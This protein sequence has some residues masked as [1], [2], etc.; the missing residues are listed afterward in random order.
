MSRFL[1]DR[2]VI[3]A[4]KPRVPVPPYLE[5]ALLC[6]SDVRLFRLPGRLSLWIAGLA[7]AAGCSTVPPP[8]T[9]PLSRTYGEAVTWSVDWGFATARLQRPDGTTEV[10]TGNG[11]S[12]WGNGDAAA[13]EL[14]FF[15]PAL[16]SLHQVSGDWDTGEYL[17]WRRVGLTARRRLATT[18]GGA[19]T[20]IASAANVHWS[21]RGVDGSIALEQTIPLGGYLTA[22]FRA[23]AS[24]GLRDYDIGVPEDLDQSAGHDNTIGGAH[25]DILR[26]DAR[27]EP[28]IGLILGQGSCILSFQPY[29]V[30]ARGAITSARCT[31]CVSGVQLLDFTQ[32]LGIAFALTIHQP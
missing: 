17:G 11:D 12:T 31:G 6:W 10:I 32:D 25:F 8:I 26:P 18:A 5:Q 27:V 13:T 9:S 30:V 20:S 14:E 23:G 19:A 7:A 22:L 21:F 2:P 28:V 24:Y 4:A 29:Y 15:V 16:A 3:P 1:P